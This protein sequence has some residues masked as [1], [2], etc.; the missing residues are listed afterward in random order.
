[1]TFLGIIL[2]EKLFYFSEAEFFISR[3]SPGMPKVPKVLFPG[4]DSHLPREKPVDLWPSPA[5]ASHGSA[6]SGVGAHP[7]RIPS[8]SEN[9]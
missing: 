3:N 2:Q 4:N 1:M 7:K 9:G 6:G 8:I 5:M